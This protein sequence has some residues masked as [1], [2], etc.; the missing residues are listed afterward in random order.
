MSRTFTS[1]VTTKTGTDGDSRPRKR[2]SNGPAHDFRFRRLPEE[3]PIS[4]W[5]VRPLFWLRLRGGLFARA[6][7][8]GVAAPV[9]RIYIPH[10]EPRG[11]VKRGIR[12]N[13]SLYCSNTPFSTWLLA[14]KHLDTLS[15]IILTSALFIFT[16]W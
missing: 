12:I 13:E 16:P 2:S 14:V 7:K 5:A 9:V 4:M 15:P 1:A 3:N 11:N 10:P 8:G 6:D